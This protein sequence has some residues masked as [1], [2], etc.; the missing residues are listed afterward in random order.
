MLSCAFQ[1]AASCR[2]RAVWL[3]ENKAVLLNEAWEARS[4][5]YPIGRSISRIGI[6]LH[7]GAAEMD[8]ALEE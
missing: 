6:R 2:L 3:S 4:R 8:A 7:R 1:M 5:G